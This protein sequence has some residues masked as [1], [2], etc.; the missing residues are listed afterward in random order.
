MTADFLIVGGGIAGISAAARLSHLGA[1]T[2]VEAEGHLAYHASG[3]S[4]ALYEP[5]YGP[6]PVA[7]LSR[8]SEGHLREEGGGV[9]S[10]RGLLLV[11]GQY[12]RSAFDADRRSMAMD[13]M[14]LV[15]ARGLVPILDPAAVAFTAFGD[16]AWDIDTDRLIQNFARAARANKARIVTGRRVTAIARADGRWH[17]EAGGAIYAARFIVNAAGAWADEVAR[18]A[19]VRPI[20]LAPLRRSMARIAAPGRR[21]VAAWPMIF[22]TGESWYA[23]PDAGAL[24]VSSAEEAPSHPHDAWAD[25][26]VLA[27]GLARYEAHV[28]EPVTRPIAT[29]AGLRTFAPDRVLVIGRDSSQPD[30]LW[31]AGQGGYGFQTAP[32]ASRLLADLVAGRSPEIDAAIIET[33]SPKRFS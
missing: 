3:R 1:V 7:N 18:M 12:E 9:L 14:S 22:G 2:L 8:A 6:A 29:W 26:M 27:E 10:K 16:H 5:N 20:G 13:D 32:A 4:A 30:F 21:D 33:L 24:I 31:L 15:E 25:D 28:T 19:G 11:A 23:K 17:V